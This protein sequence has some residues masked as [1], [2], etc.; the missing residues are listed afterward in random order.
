MISIDIHQML[1]VIL[2]ETRMTLKATD[3]SATQLAAARPWLPCVMAPRS[4]CRQ[5]YL[6]IEEPRV[7]GNCKG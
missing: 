4:W 6:T 1:R 5:E 7:T 2:L 3:R